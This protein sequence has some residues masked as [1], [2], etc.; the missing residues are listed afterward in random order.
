M[1]NFKYIFLILSIIGVFLSC[2]DD[3]VGFVPMSVT[4]V[5][6]V[7][8]REQEI[9]QAELAQYIIVQG[10]GLSAVS[11]ILVNDISVN[12][13]EVYIKDNELTFPI[14]RVIPSEVNN[15][16]T[17][18]SPQGT[19]TVPLTVHIP[20]LVVNG[21]FNEF[22]PAGEIMKIVG[23]F[24]DLYEINTE[25][26]KLFWGDQEMQIIR[27][28]QDTLY[29]KLPDDAKPGTKIKIISP[30]AGEIT[31]PGKYRETGNM[32]CDYDPFSGWGG[33]Q[34]V[35]NGPE[36]APITGQYSHF[37]LSASDAA[38]DEWS[39]TVA[40]IQKGVEYWDDIKQNPD[41]YV[42]KFEVNTLIPLTKR[43]INFFFQ[44][45]SYSWEPFIKGLPFDTKKEWCTISINLSDVWKGEVP[46][47]S[48]F[49][50]MGNSYAENTDIC[51]DNFRIVPKD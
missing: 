24:F 34:Y 51:F 22:T 12:M 32:L 8:D 18:L 17:L 37:K 29:F 20:K 49:Q 9:Q 44:Q 19:I 3:Q 33:G 27:A 21:M 42:L 15:L 4:K 2:S 13:D 25:S 43:K 23:D 5:S 11:S 10:E 45:L 30:I 26:G 7:L 1:K 35:S 28:L 36:P 41:N 48:D 47:G 16:I 50:V 31:V 46:A 6:T 38:D 14:P 40:I 39:A